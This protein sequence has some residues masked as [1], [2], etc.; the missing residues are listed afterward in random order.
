LLDVDTLGKVLVRHDGFMTKGTKLN[1]LSDYCAACL[2]KPLNKDQQISNWARRPLNAAQRSY[3]ALD[4]HCLV[5]MYDMLVSSE[6][7]PFVPRG[8]EDPFEDR[9]GRKFS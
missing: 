8:S 2:G 4:A 1:G 7:S 5:L 3:G 9:V 6:R